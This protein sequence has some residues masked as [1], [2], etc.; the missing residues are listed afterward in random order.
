[1]PT[2]TE[3][4]P[5]GTTI[6]QEDIFIEGAPDL[7]VGGVLKY[8]PDVNGFYWGITGTPALPVRKIGCYENF[9]ITDNLTINDIRCDTIGVVGNIT[10]RNFVE[11]SFDLKS[12]FP[13]STLKVLLR[14]SS[15]LAI[16]DAEFA[17]IGEIN[18]QD[19]TLIYF[20]KIYDTDAGDW[21]SVTGHRCQFQWDGDMQFKYGEPWM[22]GVKFRMYANQLLPSS[23]RFATMTRFDPSAL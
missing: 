23:Q 18:Q 7:W 20:S 1:M 3:Y 4:A 17:G 8:A 12:F 14:L 2:S 5:T 15:S 22:V 16:P 10:R 9:R 13:L 11:G 21:I 19:Y 6:L